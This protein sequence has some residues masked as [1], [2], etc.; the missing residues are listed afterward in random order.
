MGDNIL[1]DRLG[2]FVAKMLFAEVALLIIFGICAIPYNIFVTIFLTTFWVPL[3][4]IVNFVLL[5]LLVVYR[6]KF[7]L[8]MT[9]PLVLFPLVPYA[10]MIVNLDY[11][12][13]GLLD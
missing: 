9:L 2:S 1:Y 5:L 4:A 3:C 11:L 10:F 8:A 7:W 13:G 12:I 6:P